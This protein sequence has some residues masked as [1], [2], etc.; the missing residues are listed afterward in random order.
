[1]VQAVLRVVVSV[2]L[3][4]TCLFVI[5]RLLPG[6]PL[7]AEGTE[8]ALDASTIAARRS[9]EGLTL[10]L[11]EQYRAFLENLIRLDLGESITRRLPV[12]DLMMPRIMSTLELAAWAFLLGTVVGLLLSVGLVSAPRCLR[13]L[14]LIVTNL[15]L[16]VP[17]YWS[18]TIALFLLSTY[19]DLRQDS[20]FLPV[21]VLTFHFASP[22]AKLSASAL[23]RTISEGYVMT[24]HA[25]GLRRH[26][27]WMMHI[28]RPASIPIVSIIALQSA[29]LFSGAVI[30]EV[31]F[32]RPGLGTMLFNAINERDYPVIQGCVLFIVLVYVV[33]L[34]LA[35]IYAH[36]ADP[37]LRIMTE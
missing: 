16:A 27:I 4:A 5:I 31:I 14:L 19:F 34:T 36:W 33:S 30:T 32:L 23:E 2:W 3:A 9:A 37:R 35:D 28:L 11:L 1:M 29:L 6:D 12:T 15:G 7:L 10:P 13:R 22:V 17:V 20:L 18:G 8:A 26:T 25:K 24:A 21:L